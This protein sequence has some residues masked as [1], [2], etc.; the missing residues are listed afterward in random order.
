MSV[1]LSTIFPLDIVS[2]I[3]DFAQRHETFNWETVYGSTVI[4]KTKHVITYG[5]GPE[6]GYVYFYREREPGWYAWERNWGTAPTYTKLDGLLVQKF[7]DDIEYVSVVPPDYE[8]EEEDDAEITILDK[9]VMEE[10]LLD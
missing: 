5:G 9:Y 10:G 7:E 4:Y 8:P 2:R 6:G 1:A 3:S